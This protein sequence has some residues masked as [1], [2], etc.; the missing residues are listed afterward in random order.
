[1]RTVAFLN[2]KGGVG[3]TSLCHHLSG[4]FSG[5][6]LRVLLVDCDPQASL[7]NGLIG[8]DATWGLKT[9]ATV[10]VLY[11]GG[12]VPSTASIILETPVPSV[13][14][15]PGAESLELC[16][17]ASPWERGALQTVLRDALSEVEADYDLCLIDC[18]PSVQL[19]SWSA[20]VA[21]D[22]VVVPLQAEDYGAQGVVGIQRSI[23]RVQAGPNPSLVLLGLLITMFNKSLGVHKDYE[24]SLRDIYGDSVFTAMVPLAKDFKEA[25]MIRK[26]VNLYKPRSLATRATIAV[27]E[28]IFSRLDL[29]ANTKKVA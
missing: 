11:G 24:R 16:N 4:V 18:P 23:R 27:A 8:P 28:E 22:A 7:T 10:A 15:I 5:R 3:K 20:L 1:M 29:V 26:P 9:D 14:I 21:A 13:W 19:C 6:G 2:K 25:V 12:A 17:H